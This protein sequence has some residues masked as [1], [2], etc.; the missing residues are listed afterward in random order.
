MFKILW[1]VDFIYSYFIYSLLNFQ[2]AHYL[3]MFINK[4]KRYVFKIIIIAFLDRKIYII[5]GN[6]STVL[7]INWSNQ[8][9]S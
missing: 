4:F 5:K 1:R 7:I 9:I 6:E 8:F 2:K 3:L